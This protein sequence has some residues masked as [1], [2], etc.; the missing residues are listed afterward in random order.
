MF[1]SSFA[2]VANS[3][4]EASYHV[5]L[6]HVLH[7]D[8][9][10]SCSVPVRSRAQR[11]GASDFGG[12][13]GR[14]W[15]FERWWGWTGTGT[16]IAYRYVTCRKLD[17]LWIMDGMDIGRW[18]I[19]TLPVLNKSNA[20]FFVGP[21]HPNNSD[22]YPKQSAWALDCHKVFELPLTLYNRGIIILIMKSLMHQFSQ[23]NSRA[24]YLQH[25]RHCL[26]G[27]VQKGTQS[28]KF[29][30]SLVLHGMGLEVTGSN[31][32]KRKHF[33]FQSHFTLLEKETLL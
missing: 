6:C 13:G 28:V 15:F 11:L 8:A 4:I 30:I 21:S 32:M 3:A 20:H 31:Q 16:L 29:H 10:W 22:T 17:R 33:T 5:E 7:C 27:S 23:F 24:C 19:D 25:H 9:G 18:I 26:A 2:S 12:D 14:R 1:W